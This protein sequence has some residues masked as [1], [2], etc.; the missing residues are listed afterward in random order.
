MGLGQ[1]IKGFGKKVGTGAMN[2][3]KRPFN[4][5]GRG[6]DKVGAFGTDV[7]DHFIEKGL[8]K[9]TSRYVAK[10]PNVKSN[11]DAN[12]SLLGKLAAK[13]KPNGVV[14]RMTANTGYKTVTETA[15]DDL[16]EN[17]QVK[18]SKSI[19]DI[20]NKLAAEGITDDAVASLTKEREALQAQFNRA[21]DLGMDP[22]YERGMTGLEY[23]RDYYNDKDHGG[24]RRRATAIAGAGTAI[25]AGVGARYV[26]G[27]DMTHNGSG[28]RD[29]IGV[30]FV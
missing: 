30:P 17:L 2:Q 21:S 11:T 28:K 8:D 15:S 3:A 26:T 18:Y 19:S 13:S 16:I 20:D 29:I 23:V 14:N 24:Y 1:S 5:M 6:V 4:A 27:G 22:T 25:A 7:A 10:G 12:K 9:R